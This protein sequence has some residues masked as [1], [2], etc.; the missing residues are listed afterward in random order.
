M[1]NFKRKYN[2]NEGFAKP[3]QMLN[4]FNQKLIPIFFLNKKKTPENPP[5][6]FPKPVSQKLHKPIIKS[7]NLVQLMLFRKLQ[8]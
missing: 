1:S 4:K 5:S 2:P 6:P 3:T 7:E 8:L